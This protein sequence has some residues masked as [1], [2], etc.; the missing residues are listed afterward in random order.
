MDFEI[1]KLGRLRVVG[2]TE[3]Q[4]SSNNAVEKLWT[5]I[6]KENKVEGLLKINDGELK[7]MVGVC[8]NFAEDVSFDYYV[9]VVSLQDFEDVKELHIA[10]TEYA[11]FTCKIADIKETFVK[12]YGGWID[13]VDY[14][15]TFLPNIEFYRD[16]NSCEIYVP[17]RRI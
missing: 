13:T 3:R 5:F 6:H 17:V 1:K 15:F 16:M 2:F 9:G 7:G 11:V 4:S 14:E 8:Y 12:I 10:P